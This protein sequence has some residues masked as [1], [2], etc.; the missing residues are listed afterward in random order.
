MCGS[1]RFY[2]PETQLW[3]HKRR[4]LLLV[5]PQA[6]EPATMAADAPKATEKKV[7]SKPAETPLAEKPATCL[8]RECAQR[9][10]LP[11]RV[12]GAKNSAKI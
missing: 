5:A 7:E 12:R 11:R 2:L 6:A 3:H 1:A 10:A 4:N 8:A 9:T